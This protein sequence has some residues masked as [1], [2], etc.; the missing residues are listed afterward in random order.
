[1]ATLRG[2]V[3]CSSEKPGKQWSTME[4]VHMLGDSGYQNL[5]DSFDVSYMFKHKRA[6]WG[7]F[8]DSFVL[9]LSWFSSFLD[10]PVHTRLPLKGKL[11]LSF[12][13]LLKEYFTV[14]CVCDTHALMHACV[15]AWE[16]T[17][18]THGWS[19]KDDPRQSARSFLHGA[20]GTKPGPSDLGRSTCAFSD[21]S[22]A[23]LPNAGF[24]N[25]WLKK[26]T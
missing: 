7:Y 23:P 10:E 18:V 26:K 1:M 21:T 14:V 22:T 16:C 11:Q 12:I 17:L 4:P 19:P 8:W 5:Y 24:L 20:P 6:C 15:H 2:P 13:Y 3:T 9:C 25:L